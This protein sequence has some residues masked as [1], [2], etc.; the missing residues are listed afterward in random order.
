MWTRGFT[1]HDAQISLKQYRN[2][3]ISTKLRAAKKSTNH[4]WGKKKPQ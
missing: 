4:L 3:P 1:T 2:A